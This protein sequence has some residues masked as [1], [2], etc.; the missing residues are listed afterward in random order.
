[1]DGIEH[2]KIGLDLYEMAEVL[3]AMGLYQAVVSVSKATSHSHFLCPC[4]SSRTWTEVVVVCLY[5]R[6]V[7]LASQL[8]LTLPLSVN[9]ESLAS[10]VCRASSRRIATCM[11]CSKT[12]LQLD[13]VT[14]HDCAYTKVNCIIYT[15]EW[16]C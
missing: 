15:T 3:V 9:D 8:V 16:N 7:L 13:Q 4:T 5:T 14:A 11:M 2:E 6:E 10:H 1:M 12:K